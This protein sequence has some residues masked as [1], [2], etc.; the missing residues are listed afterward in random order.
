M[1]IKRSNSVSSSLFN[2]EVFFLY[3]KFFTL[4]ITEVGG[5]KFNKSLGS[6]DPHLLFFIDLSNST[7]R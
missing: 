3:S 4:L 6:D 5:L 7:F 2:S 1:S